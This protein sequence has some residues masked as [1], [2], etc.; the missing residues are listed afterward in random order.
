[1]E[2]VDQILTGVRHFWR[3]GGAGGVVG[4]GGCGFAL[5]VVAGGLGDRSSGGCYTRTLRKASETCMSVATAT[6]EV[7]KAGTCAAVGLQGLGKR[8]LVFGRRQLGQLDV[9]FRAVEDRGL[10]ALAPSQVTSADGL[11]QRGTDADRRHG[12]AQDLLEARA[13]SSHLYQTPRRDPDDALS[14]FHQDT[15]AAQVLG[16]GQPA[17]TGGLFDLGVQSLQLFSIRRDDQRNDPVF[18]GRVPCDV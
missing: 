13:L 16:P 1:M 9:D 3:G 7:T 5:T 10:A 6:T 4:L 12:L 2:R 11:V 8:G 15:G 14:A 18:N 17:V